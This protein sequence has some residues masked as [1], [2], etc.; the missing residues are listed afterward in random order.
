M[1]ITESTVRQLEITE[2]QGLDPIRVMLSDLGQ[3]QGRI[4]IECWGKSWASFWGGMGDRTIAEF[5]CSCH[6]DY[7]AK[8]L[9]PNLPLE[10]FDPEYLTDQLKREVIK[11]RRRGLISGGFARERFKTINELDLPETEEQLWSIASELEQIMG[12]EWW[13]SIP[14]TP[15]PD[16]QYLC[17]IIRTVQAALRE[18]TNGPAEAAASGKG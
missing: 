12:E 4:N 13:Y 7:L 9:D 17:R 16:Y 6:E 3:G 11:E 10:I 5:F 2:V 1:K 14:K 8:N 15:N 18:F